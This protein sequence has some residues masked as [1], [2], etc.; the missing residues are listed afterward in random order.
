MF[1]SFDLKAVITDICIVD[2]SVN[3]SD[4]RSLYCTINCLSNLHSVSLFAKVKVKQSYSIRWNKANLTD[5][6]NVTRTQLGSFKFYY[7]LIHCSQGCQCSVHKQPINTYYHNIVNV[8]SAVERTTVP[9]ISHHALCSFWN[10][11]LD[12]LKQKLIFWPTL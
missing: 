6:Y 5:Y 3:Y 4:L 12:D 10:N 1:A 8:L 2:S 7:N 11:E 9:H